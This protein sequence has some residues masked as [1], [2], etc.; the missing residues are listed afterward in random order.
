MLRRNAGPWRSACKIYA[1]SGRDVPVLTAKPQNNLSRFRKNSR[2]R[3]IH[4]GG[5]RRV[6]KPASIQ[7]RPVIVF[8]YC[9]LPVSPLDCSASFRLDFE[10]IGFLSPIRSSVGWDLKRLLLLFLL[11][12]GFSALAQSNY[13]VLGGSISDPQQRRSEER[14]VGEEWRCVSG[15]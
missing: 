2:G 10:S 5:L 14:R 4:R 13:A 8:Y 3:L 12:F 11:S 6:K 7:Y 9:C 1:C 15:R